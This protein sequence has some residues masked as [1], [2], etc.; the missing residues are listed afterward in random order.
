MNKRRYCT[1]VLCKE[2]ISTNNIKKHNQ[3]CKEKGGKFITRKY[4]VLNTLECKYCGR[5]CKNNNSFR[6]HEIR[7]KNNPNKITV[8]PSYGMKGKCGSNQFI[9]A[10]KLGLPAPIV[11][12]NTR[13][14][15]SEN[16]KRNPKSFY[17]KSSQLAIVKILEKLSLYEV[18]EIY[19][20]TKNKEWFLNNKGINYCYDLCFKD[21]K[22]IVEYN[23]STY[24]VKNINSDWVAPYQNMGSKYDVYEKDLIKKTVAE[25]NGYT[26][27]VIWDDEEDVGIDNV[28]NYIK[29][30]LWPNG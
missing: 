20:A 18:G 22:L 5:L 15:H 4:E 30:L 26:V 2:L 17:S 8:I 16:N 14:K 19:Y 1:C 21:L 23:G 24:H 9:K 11:S 25:N 27:L 29:N 28:V 12:D 10:H 13:R 6:Q 3:R 7:C